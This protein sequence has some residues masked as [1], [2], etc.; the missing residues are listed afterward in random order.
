MMPL[1][2]YKFVNVDT[3]NAVFLLWTCMK[4]HDVNDICVIYS[5]RKNTV[6]RIH[7]WR[8]RSER[9]IPSD[10]TPYFKCSHK[11]NELKSY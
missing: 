10:C 3:G 4:F 2:I 8:L 6:F 1:S 11:N 5:S 7:F 9:H